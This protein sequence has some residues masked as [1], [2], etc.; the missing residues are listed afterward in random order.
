MTQNRRNFL[1]IIATYG[2]S[3]YALVIA[4]GALH[5]GVM[6]NL[7]PFGL[8]PHVSSCCAGEHVTAFEHI[9]ALALV[10]LILHHLLP[11][12]RQKGCCCGG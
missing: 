1:N 11:N 7:L 8:L 12:D 4:L 10:L 2:R 3:L 6:I 9:A 5:C